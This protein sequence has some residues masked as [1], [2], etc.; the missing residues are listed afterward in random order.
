M[1]VSLTSVSM[2]PPVSM[3]VL[4][5]PPVTPISMSGP[6]LGSTPFGGPQSNCRVSFGSIFDASSGQGGDNNG[7]DGNGGTMG[8]RTV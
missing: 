4:G 6:T 5:G 1:I 8:S 3:P 2:Q 7:N